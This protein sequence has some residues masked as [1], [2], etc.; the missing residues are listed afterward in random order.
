MKKSIKILYVLVLFVGFFLKTFSQNCTSLN[1]GSSLP[2][3]S[4][5]EEIS[6]LKDEYYTIQNKIT[7]LTQVTEGVGANVGD[8]VEFLKKKQ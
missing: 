2:I 5:D 6:N 1:Y 8:E 7:A 3:N 4:I